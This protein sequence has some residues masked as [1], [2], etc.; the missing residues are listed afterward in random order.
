MTLALPIR[1]ILPALQKTLAIKQNVVLVAEPG[2]GKTTQVPLALLQES[3]LQGQRI[4]MLEPRRVAARA[5][6]R[7]MARQLG[8]S[9]GQTVG[10][11]VRLE[12][13]VSSATRLEVVTEG[14]LTRMLQEDAELSGV[15]LVI[16][17]EFHERSLQADVGLALCLETQQVLRPDL[18]LLVMSATLAAEAVAALLETDAVL[19]CP[20]R[21]FPVA[22]HYWPYPVDAD[23]EN[24]VLAAVRKAWQEETGDILVFLPGVP[25]IRRLL[26]QL[27]QA[28]LPENCLLLP[29]HGQLT[30][31][32]QDAA[33]AAAPAGRRKIVLATAIAETSVTVE[34]VRIVIDS[35]WMRVAR[36]SA[37]SGM[38]YLATQRVD[39]AAAAQRRGRAGRLGPGV[40]YR[41][42]STEQEARLNEYSLPEIAETDLAPL[43]L[44]LAAWGVSDPA[45][46]RWLDQP[47]AQHWQQAQNLLQLLG[48]LDEQGRITPLGRQMNALG[49]HPRL[50]KM[51]ATAPPGLNK[52]AAWLASLLSERDLLARRAAD[53]DLVSRL[54]VLQQASEN[55][56]HAADSELLPACR[57]L[58]QLAAVWQK[59]SGGNGQEPLVSAAAGRLLA[60]AYPDR[61]A[62]RRP[63]GR[64]LLSN[65][66]GAVFKR[67][68]LLSHQPFL[69]VTEIDDQGSD[70]QIWL[71]AAV[72]LETLREVL[73]GQ[74]SSRCEVWWETA[75]QAVRCR[76]QEVLGTLVLKETP[77]EQAPGE[78]VLAALLE[79]IR[80]VGLQQ[81]LA[82]T[83]ASRQLWL[84]LQFAERW[85]DDWPAYGEAALL[86]SMEEWLAPFVFGI[87]SLQG[88]QTLSTAELLLSRLSWE[89][90]SWLDT[91]VPTHITVPSGQRIPLDYS[92]AAQPVLAVRLQEVFG[93]SVT[94]CIA[95]GQVPLML[96]LLSPAQ[97]P[98]QVTRDLANF[99][100]E[101][102]FAVKKELQGRYP[103]HYWPDDPWTAVPTHRAK[104]R[105]S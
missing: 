77:A 36:F 5:A 87:N 75:A 7:Y 20:G 32:E 57:R 91:A 71:A 51:L 99:W 26:R 61:I 64:F 70:G 74:L 43:V 100:R 22:T 54:E 16:F 104:P 40:C 14:V 12:S 8:E 46:V 30:A 48:A 39:K 98:V 90:R 67:P 62:Q 68:E 96:H 102:Y 31:A 76:Q 101:T 84:R 85:R 105:L 49:L 17:D 59:R 44:D 80:S 42:W 53:S 1:E 15:G 6:A 23:W 56:L 38:S 103:K 33:L 13:C 81:A 21:T 55:R 37:R 41:L 45:R 34:G 9:V 18:R 52:T 27:E 60:L 79:G 97:R 92:D 28:A 83:K 95:D 63:D 69:V 50:A 58:L 19:R 47:P 11:R 25:E 82:W 94:P 73:A 2:A 72:T 89:Q 86:Q 10:Y 4:I 66:R 29:L 88:V 93:W 3:W 35:G 78:A 65:G 24:I